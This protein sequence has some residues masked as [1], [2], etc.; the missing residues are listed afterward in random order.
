RGFLDGAARFV[1]DAAVF[2]QPFSSHSVVNEVVNQVV[3]MTDLALGIEHLREQP[4][5]GQIV[6]HPEQE[7]LDER[8]SIGRKL[9]LHADVDLTRSILST[10][11]NEADAWKE[12][13]EGEVLGSH[14]RRCTQAFLVALAQ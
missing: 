9:V 5:Q 12:L 11:P 7:L 3:C 10:W 4:F 13:V 1:Q 8:Q 14:S 6:G 2:K